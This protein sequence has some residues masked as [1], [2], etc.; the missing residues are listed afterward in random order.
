MDVPTKIC[1][2]SSNTSRQTEYTE[3]LI[4]QM[5]AD[6]EGGKKNNTRESILEN[7]MQCMLL[8][9]SDSACHRCLGFKGLLPVGDCKTSF[10]EE[11]LDRAFKEDSSSFDN[12]APSCKKIRSFESHLD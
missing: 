3:T 8:R 6:C 2:R 5:P 11:E 7:V 12:A 10:Y 1:K 4:N 9:L